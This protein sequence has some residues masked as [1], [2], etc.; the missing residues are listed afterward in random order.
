MVQQFF[1]SDEKA[2]LDKQRDKSG[3]DPDDASSHE[4]EEST[5]TISVQAS[6]VE[7]TKATSNGGA[8][9][10]SK[11]KKKRKGSAV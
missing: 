7:E 4:L 5:A 3:C 2:E 6:L 8:K 10:V 9:S 11:G 1:S